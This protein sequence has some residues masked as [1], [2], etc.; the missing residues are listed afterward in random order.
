MDIMDKQKMP[1]S[2]TLRGVT[3]TPALFCA[4]MAAIT[5]SAFRRLLAGFGGYGALFTEMLSAKM[6]LHESLQN[7]PWLKRRPE[8][9]RVIYQLMADDTVNLPQII[10]RL[11][12]LKPDG[13]DL[14]VACDAHMVRKQGGGSDLFY[15]MPRLREIVRV[16]RNSFSGPLTAKIRLGNE[17]PDWRGRFRERIRLLEGEGVDALTIHPRFYEEKFKRCARQDLYAEI[18]RETNLPI[19]ANG[20]INGAEFVKEHAAAFAPVSGIM[21][22]RMAAACPWIFAMWHN[23]GLVVDRAET[24]NRLCDYIA[25]DFTE[26]HA[27]IRMKIIAPYFARNFSFGHE[28]FK[29]VHNAPDVKTAREQA[30]RFFAGSA[31]LV[32]T[33]DVS[34]I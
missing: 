23:P 17:C 29:A 22:G 13:L 8:E 12:P 21:I 27:L 26:K 24:W 32:K 19:I 3:F 7:S 18:T 33:I 10:D 28:F 5:H 30:D 2:L 16:M 15:D 31:E 6:I 1:G 4:P 14:N 9:G 11:A 34:G 20:D 25:E